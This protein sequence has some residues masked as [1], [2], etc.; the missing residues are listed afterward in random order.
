VSRLKYGVGL[1]KIMLPTGNV[2]GLSSL[3][4]YKNLSKGEKR[5][6]KSWPT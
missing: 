5:G 4:Y 2:F 3:K 6:T 1:T